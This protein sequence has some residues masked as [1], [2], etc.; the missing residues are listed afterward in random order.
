M[1]RAIEHLSF[2]ALGWLFAWPV[3]EALSFSGWPCVVLGSFLAMP[4]AVLLR[5]VFEILYYAFTGK[6]VTP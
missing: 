4:A 2:A 1:L 6:T 3:C 5:I